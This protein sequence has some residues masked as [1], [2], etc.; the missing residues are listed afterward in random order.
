MKICQYPSQ[1]ADDRL[2]KIKSRGLEYSQDEINRV[3]AILGDVRE[4][5]DVALL[6]YTQEFDAPGMT[7]DKIMATEDEIDAARKSVDA[8]FMRALERAA[9]QIEQ[10]HHL[11]QR[12]SWWDNP[13]A[14]VMLGQIIRPVNRA[15]LYIPGGRGGNTPLISSVLMCGIPARL[16]GVKNIT[17]VTP[18][19]K[20]NS[21]S[22]HLLCAARR[23]GVTR[24]L[25]LGS[26][27]GIAALAYGTQSVEKVDVI[28]GP[29]NLYVTLA[30]KLV[31]GAVGIDMV[32]GPSEILIVADDSAKPDF[33]A[34]DMLGQAEHDA[35]ASSVLITTSATLA[36]KTLQSLEEQLQTLPR[37]EIAR[38]SLAD[39]GAVMVVKDLDGAFKLAN[40]LAPEHLEL[41]TENP[42]GLLDKIE[43][44]GA[45]FIGGYT[46]EAMGDYVAGTNHVLPTNGT[47]RFASALSMEHF[48]KKTSMIYYSPEAFKLEADDVT[49]LAR[50]EGL[51]AHA[52]SVEV[53]RKA[54]LE[55]DLDKA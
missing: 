6:R 38:K 52:A 46:P 25:K 50:L 12:C 31:S 45:V 41:V 15:G 17:M 3:A 22:P 10:F 48:M 37:A 2:S 55:A 18:A 11:Q 19:R 5:G 43:N 30:K 1:Q 9:V 4:N 39:Y 44:A 26:A 29:G 54:L 8:V 23:A 14:G 28:V 21:I 53:R 32:A 36:Q 42:L 35:R 34:A 7:L 16:A 49:T 24:I 47:A 33:V 27:W 20:D 51:D 13:R 40:Y